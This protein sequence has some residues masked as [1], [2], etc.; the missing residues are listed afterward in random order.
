EYGF[1]AE[2]VGTAAAFAAAER[3]LVIDG[4]WTAG[5]MNLTYP[6]LEGQWSV[7]PLPA[8]PAGKYTA[9]IGGKGM[10]ILSYSDNV[11][12]AFDL[13]LFLGSEEAA[14]ALTEGYI[15]RSQIYV[16]TKPDFAQYIQGSEELNEALTS[17]LQD[18]AGPPNC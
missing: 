6:E 14:Q 11:D 1:P 4:E 13:M 18:A 3:D 8:G 10:G 2:E 12:A 15:A 9:F 7:A 5:G 17:Q 16:P